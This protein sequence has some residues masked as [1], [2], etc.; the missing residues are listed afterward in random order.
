MTQRLI[1]AYQQAPW[2]IQVQRLRT[3][4]LLIL[5][6]ALITGMYLFVS[7]QAAMAGL[8]IQDK[9]YEREVLLREIASLKIQLGQLSSMTSM[10]A[11]AIKAGFKPV[12]ADKGMYVVVSGYY[13]RPPL[14]LAPAPGPDLL[15]EATLKPEYTQS[16]WEFLFQKFSGGALP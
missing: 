2:R 13:G 12:A 5:A 10:E 15:P 6:F 11:R 7:A 4:L 16:L 1:Q 3:F 14:N 9:E 8:N